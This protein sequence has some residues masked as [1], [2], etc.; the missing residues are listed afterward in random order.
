M[1]L[2]KTAFRAAILASAAMALAAVGA[3]AV[4]VLPWIFDATVPW[5]VVAPFARGLGAVALEAALFVGWPI[6]WALGVQRLV[7]RGEAL[8]LL[9]LG[10]RPART[11]LR[12]APQAML[13]A[14][15]LA[16]VSAIGGRDAREP[17]RVVTERLSEGKTACERATAPAVYA[18]PFS[19][20]TWLC[21]PGRAAPRLVGHAPGDLHAA[22]FTAAGARVS[23]DLRQIELSDAWFLLGAKSNLTVHAA[24]VTL[25]GLPPWARAS[26]LPT[27]MRAALFA[28]AAAAAAGLSAY[29]ALGFPAAR[30]RRVHAILLGASGPLAALGTLRA[31]ERADARV[32]LFALVPLAATA[33]TLVVAWLLARLLR[34]RTT[35]RK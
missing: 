1:P 20:T 18:V 9:T 15:V 11:L 33:S 25:R 26:T 22:L 4:R 29:F 23:D 3:G 35:A 16:G 2:E 8:V 17:G 6:G 21:N 24:D 7:E 31:F 34:E 13:L 27:A 32:P 10:E 30:Y 5:H 28:L 12:L 19:G 14:S